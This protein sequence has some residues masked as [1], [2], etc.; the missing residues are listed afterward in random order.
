MEHGDFHG[1]KKL[2]LKKR[3]VMANETNE[4]FSLKMLRRTNGGCVVY[5]VN[6]NETE[7]WL[8][9]KCVVEFRVI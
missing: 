3:V 7:S 5:V 4:K 1:P 6:E 2:W 9:L 8:L